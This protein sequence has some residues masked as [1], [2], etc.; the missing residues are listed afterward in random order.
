MNASN[1]TVQAR[2]YV[3]RE[4]IRKFAAVD[5]DDRDPAITRIRSESLRD[6]ATTA[7]A[8]RLLLS[9]GIDSPPVIVAGT[10]EHYT[11]TAHQGHSTLTLSGAI[12][13]AVQLRYGA[14]GRQRFDKLEVVPGLA[15]PD[16][17]PTSGSFEP[18]VA[19]CLPGCGKARQYTTEGTCLSCGHGDAHRGHYVEGGPQPLRAARIE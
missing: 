1:T 6:S 13:D 11:F 2:L 14:S 7:E 4:R 10:D 8:F 3:N 16:A 19:T 12:D 18:E 5:Q 17:V 15:W 9:G